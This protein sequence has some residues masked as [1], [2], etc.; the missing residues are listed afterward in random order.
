MSDDLDRRDPL[1]RFRDRFSLEPGVVYLDGNSLGP[2]PADVG[3]RVQ[4]TI[5]E[6]RTELI[7]GWNAGWM[8]LPRRVGAKLAGLL[9]ASDDEV[10][11][12]DSTSINLFNVAIAA[13]RLRPERTTILT[14]DDN[15]PSDR[16][17][18]ASVARLAGL[19]LR[20]VSAS[21]VEAAIDA[22]TAL[23]ALTHVGYRTGA[24]YDIAAIT[25][26]AHRHGAVVLWDLAHSAGVFELA[27][28]RDDVDLA[29]G[30]GY[31]YLNGGPGA[32][33]F[34][35]AARRLHD[36]LDQPLTAWLGHE[37]PFAFA[38]EYRPAAGIE[39][40]RTGTP[41]VLSL[42]ALDAGL[43]TYAGVDLAAVRAKSIALTERFLALVDAGRL[44]RH[45][46]ILTPRDARRR[47]SQISL[48]H[49]H[50]PAVVQALS[51]RRVIGDFRPPDIIR[52]GFAPLY[53]RYADVDA[54]VGQLE[55]I[56]ESAP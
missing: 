53:V 42:V 45:V 56:S 50:A 23:V 51:E 43:D 20:T 9:G 26:M 47:G 52:F 18:L 40:L 17:I 30:C 7:G 6:W 21:A 19:A 12:A 48:R 15:F 38:D 31:K 44:H 14:T 28:D 1:A 34:M 24:A 10:I 37:D 2:P 41:P 33:A 27:L 39:R 11:V 54:A 55:K 3:A 4:A 36:R 22:T 5:D 8:D 49:R 46:E 32:P 13:V 16:Y 25:R 35:F 29:I